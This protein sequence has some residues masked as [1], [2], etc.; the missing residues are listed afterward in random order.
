MDKQA[1]PT[2]EETRRDRRILR[3][4]IEIIDAA[5]R[6][7]AQKGYAGATTKDIANAADIGESTL[8]NYFESK[9][10]IL[11]AILSQKA[12]AVDEI[13]LSGKP[14]RREDVV[15]TL[16]RAMEIIFS[17][18]QYTRALI[19]EAWL[20]N[21]ILI[22]YLSNRLRRIVD[23]LMQYFREG[24]EAGVFRPIDPELAVRIFLGM[25]SG[26]TLPALRGAE[27]PPDPDRRRLL[28][29][30]IVSVLLDGLKAKPL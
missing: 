16:D 18:P 25:F 23:L 30:T 17:Q 9:R 29:E 2:K 27:P 22:N 21:D 10:D 1:L 12:T 13:I 6:V 11:L 28:A 20:D 24:V 5:A 19:A 7:F 4:R 14:L 15:N 8:Y 3:K 26:A